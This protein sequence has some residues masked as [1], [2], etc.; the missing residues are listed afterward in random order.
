MNTAGDT[1]SIEA[2]LEGNSDGSKLYCTWTQ[3][4]FAEYGEDVVESDA[5]G[6]RLWWIDDYISD[7]NAWT[8]PGTNNTD[9]T[10][11]L[12]N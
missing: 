12:A 4:V 8:L 9:T 3:W 7:E 10:T 2:D 11:L 1:H 6:R 5:M